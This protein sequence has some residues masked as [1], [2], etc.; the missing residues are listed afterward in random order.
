[1]KTHKRHWGF[2][3]LLHYCDLA[4]R[5]IRQTPFISVLMV[6]AIGI[7]IGVTMT[8]LSVY[9]MK[10]ADPIPNKSARLHALQLQI[11]DDGQTWRT[12]DNLPQQVTYQDAMYLLEHSSLEKKVAMF[13]SGAAIHLDKPDS[14]PFIKDVRVTSRDF[15]DMFGM[16]FLYGNVW[17]EAQSE[18][19][20]PVVVISEVLSQKL[21][22]RKNALGESVYLGDRRH[23]VVGVTKK[24]HP[25]VKFY[26]VNNSAFDLAE[27]V[28]IPLSHAEAYRVSSWGNTNGWKNEDINSFEQFLNSETVW[29]QFWVELNSASEK[30]QYGQFLLDYMREQQ[31]LG[32][33]NRKELEYNLQPVMQW[34]KYNHVVSADNK[35]LVGLSFMFLAVCIAN[36]LGMLLAK[37]L[38]RAP[39]AGVRRALGASK[40]QIF[41]QH[42]VEVAILG[43]LGSVVGVVLAQLGLAGIRESKSGYELI[44]TMDWQMLLISPVISILACLIAGLFPAWVVCKTSPATHLKIQ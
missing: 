22:G 16:S 27:E 14:A 37:F 4:W 9:H 19:A 2:N 28:F 3:M 41:Y 35:I 40:R 11:M 21:F 31:Q 34:L 17:S 18:Q 25:A 43:L 8:T 42:L 12:P 29:L 36:I 6:I 44:A 7:G 32:R 39:D 24:W 15:F 13:K 1:M 33:F 30:A 5:N 38:K 23:E 10:S 20:A 26:D